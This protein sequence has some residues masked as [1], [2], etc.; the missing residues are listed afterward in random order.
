[1]CERGAVELPRNLQVPID[2]PLSGPWHPLSTVFLPTLTTH[3]CKA[4]VN[5]GSTTSSHLGL[6]MTRFGDKG[7]FSGGLFV[8]SL[9]RTSLFRGPSLHDYVLVIFVQ[10]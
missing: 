10:R 4:C 9:A 7:I 6:A 3:Q 2:C 5:V 1:M 8:A